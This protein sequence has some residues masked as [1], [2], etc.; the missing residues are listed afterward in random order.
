LSIGAV[1]KL[2]ADAGLQIGDIVVTEDECKLD[3]DFVPACL[4]TACGRAIVDRMEKLEQLIEKVR[5]AALTALAEA[6]LKRKGDLKLGEEDVVRGKFLQSESLLHQLAYNQNRIFDNVAGVSCR[7]L[8]NF[9]SGMVRGF[10]EA[11]SIYA[12]LRELVRTSAIGGEWGSTPGGTLMPEL[13]EYQKAHY[14]LTEMTRFFDD[15]ERVMAILV[16]ILTMYSGDVVGPTVEE[17]EIDGHRF[18]K[19][20]H[21]AVKYSRREKR[22]FL[23]IDGVEPRGTRDVAIRISKRILSPAYAQSAIFYLGANDVD[24]IAQASVA[25]RPF[26]DRTA[27]DFWVVMPIELLPIK[28]D[29][30]DRLNVIID[31]EVDAGA[32][33]TVKMEDVA[34]FSRPR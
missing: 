3:P 21:G 17:I 11:F 16:A 32:L 6:K 9:F 7:E 30:L 29:S 33:E 19:Q 24:D 28:V 8:I 18:Q 10:N 14:G 23:I 25:R 12:E 2:P 27:P 31:G 26:E 4:T 1:E 15:T 20:Q 13:A 22:H 5:K 34:I